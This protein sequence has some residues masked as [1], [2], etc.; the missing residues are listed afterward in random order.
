V[1]SFT[2]AFEWLPESAGCWQYSVGLQHKDHKIAF[3]GLASGTDYKSL[4]IQNI[5]ENCCVDQHSF[6][7]TAKASLNMAVT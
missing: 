4:I 6:H 5:F 7:F 2:S 3:A 1:V